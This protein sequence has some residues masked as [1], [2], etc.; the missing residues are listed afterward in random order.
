MAINYLI[1]SPSDAQCFAFDITTY[2]YP[3]SEGIGHFLDPK[4]FILG[5]D[6]FSIQP[7]PG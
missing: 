7:P 1:N 2:S 4:P 3:I 5:G 6:A